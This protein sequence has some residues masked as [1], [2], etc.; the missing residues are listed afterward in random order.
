[1]HLGQ[2]YR[3]VALRKNVDGMIA[4]PVPVFWNIQKK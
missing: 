1:V 4:A 2:W 3:P